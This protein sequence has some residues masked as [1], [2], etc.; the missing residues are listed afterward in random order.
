M[1]EPFVR[2]ARTGKAPEPAM[3]AVLCNGDVSA[4]LARG[5]LDIRPHFDARVS[6][7]VTFRVLHGAFQ[8]QMLRPTRRERVKGWWYAHRW[9][10][11]RFLIL[12]ASCLAA[13]LALNLL[14]D[15]GDALADWVSAL[16]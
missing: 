14:M 6:H 15:A 2:N 3:L 11:G 7:P 8:P 9:E 4:K 16:W 10:I 12:A 1:P 13:F 5:G